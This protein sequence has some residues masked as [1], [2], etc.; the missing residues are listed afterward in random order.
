VTA[1]LTCVCVCLC[2]CVL[3]SMLIQNIPNIPS[4]YDICV[5]VVTR[6]NS[7]AKYLPMYWIKQSN[8]SIIAFHL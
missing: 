3:L 8:L 5:F 1:V 6:V 2:V 4:Q 7:I